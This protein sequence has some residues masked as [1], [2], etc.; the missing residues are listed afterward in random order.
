MCKCEE[1]KQAAEEEL[2]K[3][4]QKSER[5]KNLK[6]LSLLGRRY[7]N[8]AFENSEI[9]MNPSFDTALNHCKKYCENFRQM[10]ET[11]Q[12]I[13]IY[14]EFGVGK[15]HLTACIVNELMTNFVPV[16]FTN[17]FEISKAIKTTFGRLCPKNI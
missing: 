1:A 14:G 5:I 8:A 16:L 15:T 10:L 4:R 17:L 2:Q 3:Q 6:S 13:Y 9:G 12:G 7:E 11:G